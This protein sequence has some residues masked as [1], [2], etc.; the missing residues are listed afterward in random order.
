MIKQV[1]MLIVGESKW[2]LKWEVFIQCFGAFFVR[3]KLFGKKKF[4]SG[5]TNMD[6]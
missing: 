1:K 4:N 5:R 6:V 3:L 2:W